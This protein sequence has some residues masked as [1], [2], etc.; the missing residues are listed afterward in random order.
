LRAISRI[1]F[2]MTLAIDRWLAGLLAPSLM[3]GEPDPVS[4]ADLN[5]IDLQP[6]VSSSGHVHRF[7]EVDLAK[8]RSSGCDV[9]VHLGT[10]ILRGAILDA[11]PLGILSFHHGDNRHYRGGPPGY[12]EVIHRRDSTGWILQRLTDRLDDGIIY[13]RGATWTQPL[14]EWN[15]AY[16]VATSAHALVELLE[17][18]ALTES[19]PTPEPLTQPGPLYRFPSGFQA[20]H[21]LV[22]VGTR[23]AAQIVRKYVAPR[24]EWA[25]LVAAG[26]WS[27]PGER[28]WVPLKNP[29]RTFVA[30]PFVVME[31]GQT[32]VFVEEFDRVKGRAAI[33]VYDGS[34]T[35]PTRLGIA[36]S[37]PFHLSFPF[38]FRFEGDLYMSPESWMVE[39]IRIYRC[40]EFPLSWE[41]C[42]SHLDG[43]KYVD[44][45]IV[46]VNDEWTIL[47]TPVD[48]RSG[49]AH[50]RLEAFSLGRTP[51]GAPR[52]VSRSPVVFDS[53]SARNG[54]LVTAGTSRFRCGQRQG[55]GM[56]G[57]DLRLFEI[58][59]CSPT[60]YREV[61]VQL[62]SGLRPSGV[63][64][65]HHLSATEDLTAIDVYR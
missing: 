61:E 16:V 3:T 41:L 65:F 21:G 59:E 53:E 4:L 15:R 42:H 54:G 19:P 34:V 50:S 52:M 62:P 33:A 10:G 22:K 1:V 17:S 26:T 55:F 8:V 13:R 45:M 32:V 7:G 23:S 28:S 30:D 56:Y 47:A 57:E 48:E 25:V 6:T 18:V 63:R 38:I 39:Q 44:P 46:S 40:I 2:E 12:W 11:V 37:E 27:Q 43:H 64:G 36:I 58:Q 49:D 5:Q 35:S 51:F 29:P 24:P 31:G 20:I 9:L 14:A 60:S